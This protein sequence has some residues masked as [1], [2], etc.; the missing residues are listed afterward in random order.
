MSEPG[1]SAALNGF[2]YQIFA[3]LHYISEIQLSATLDGENIQSA[4]LILEPQGGGGDARYEGKNVRIVDQYKTRTGDRTWSLNDLIQEVLPDLFLAVDANRLHEPCRYRFVTDG[5]RGRLNHFERFLQNFTPNTIPEDPLSI[6]DN[7]LFYPFF[8]NAPCTDHDLFLRIAKSVRPRN[9]RTDPTTHYRKLWHLSAR[10]GIENEISAS[11]FK[12]G[13]DEFLIQ[14]VDAREDVESKRRELCTIIMELAAEG[15]AIC[16]PQDILQ[17]AHLNAVPLSDLSLLKQKLWGKTEEEFARKGYDPK[18]DVRA[19]PDWPGDYPILLLA[20]ESG[21]GKTWQLFRLANH[22]Q[23]TGN[24]VVLVSSDDDAEK[25]LQEVSD[26]VWLACLSHD[27]TLPFRCLTVRYQEI[28]RLPDEPWL[29]ICLDNVQEINEIRKLVEKP[30]KS[31]RIKLAL[32]IPL[33]YGRRIAASRRDD[34]YLIELKEFTSGE[35]LVFFK[36]HGYDWGEIPEDVRKML[37]RPILAK[38]YCE[39]AADANWAPHNEYELYEKYWN[40]IIHKDELLQH[41]DDIGIFLQLVGFVLDQ[42]ARYPLNYTQRKKAGLNDEVLGRL[43]K[44]GLLRRVRRGDVEVWHDRILNWAVAE[45]LIDQ[46][47]AGDMQLSELQE[48]LSQMFGNERAFAGKRLGYVLLDYL[49]LACDP[50]NEVQKDILALLQVLEKHPVNS[51]YPENFY[52]DHISTLGERVL[53]FLTERLRTSLSQTEP[54]K[55]IPRFV[56]QALINIGAKTPEPVKELAVQFV[57][58]H[59]I[60]IQAA[61]MR[62]LIELPDPRVLNI[63]WELHKPHFY[64]LQNSPT[65]EDYWNYE[66]SLPALQACV[67]LASQW[68]VKKVGDADPNTEPVS[69]LGWLLMNLV[70][71][72]EAKRIWGE[73][74]K[75]LFEKVQFRKVRSLIRCI[76]RFKDYEEIPKLLSWLKCKDDNAN[77]AAFSALC[78]LDVDKALTHIG[79]LDINEASLCRTWWVP[80]LFLRVPQ[81]AYQ[82]LLAVAKTHEEGFVYLQNVYC[83]YENHIDPKTLDFF[84]ESLEASLKKHLDKVL[85]TELTGLYYSLKFL[86][87]I[88]KLDLLHII[89]AKANTQF[90]NLLLQVAQSRLKHLSLSQ[91]IMFSASHDVLCKIC[92]QGVTDL[93]NE[94]LASENFWDRQQGLKDALLRPNERTS[95]LLHQIVQSDELFEDPPR[96]IEQSQAVD[97]L[98]VL[99]DNDSVIDGVWRWGS[100]LS[101]SVFSLCKSGRSLRNQDIQKALDIVVKGTDS[102]VVNALIVLGVSGNHEFIPVIRQVLEKESPESLTARFAAI[103][104]MALGDKSE[105]FV[106]LLTRFLATEDNRSTAIDCLYRIDSSEALERLVEHLEQT[107]ERNDN[108]WWELV[109]A[110]FQKEEIRHKVSKILADKIRAGEELTIYGWPLEILDELGIENAYEKLIEEALTSSTM[111]PQRVTSAIKGL[112]KFNPDVAYQASELALKRLKNV[113]YRLP[114]M[115]VHLSEDR[116]I[117]ILCKHIPSEESASIRWSIG[118]ALRLVKNQE[119]LES[120]IRKMLAK[121]DRALRKATVEIIGWQP[122]GFMQKELESLALNDFD[123]EVSQEAI[124]AL[125][126]QTEQQWIEEL[127]QEFR[128][129]SSCRR[130]SLLTSI[131]ELG[132]PFILS[133]REDVLWIEQILNESPPEYWNFASQQIKRRRKAVVQEAKR[134]DRKKY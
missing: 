129:A 117:D 122:S 66:L 17:R 120:Y 118:R 27:H 69:E 84:L 54:Y 19:V 114:R 48:L 92:G 76:G 99:G 26:S 59:D 101:W 51:G 11:H 79:Q 72:S 85:T 134:A 37:R 100:E 125:Q 21:Q 38:I 20:S 40:T 35:M 12:R 52:K 116:A 124:K 2:L 103:A 130:W 33:E 91:D 102:N 89:K 110:L 123:D 77:M 8:N 9:D 73:T 7:I 95:I 28:H 4:R 61:G 93:I 49:W 94:A 58:K 50:E 41:S 74:K 132:D 53:P 87:R 104:L 55:L 62:I 71:S 1:G 34:I 24:S 31:W 13:I 56:T 109:F 23:T 39:I 75:T 107:K 112:W 131:L 16:T 97:L 46:R 78:Q 121:P 25:A 86:S 83:D 5:R 126:R 44:V 10:F 30:W 65:R 14:V 82:M 90:E 113:D 57:Q 115:L 105:E 106:K 32:T 81:Q 43:E 60:E 42:D 70:D 45:W 111:F 127:M 80:E 68:L 119:T 96:P 18:M 64:A 47:R 67:Q 98:V 29:I 6:L 108:K 3:N 36:R 133:E 128:M 63:L 22:L 15:H 88:H